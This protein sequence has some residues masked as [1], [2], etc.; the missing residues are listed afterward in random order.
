MN[1]AFC[2]WRE[3][4]ALALLAVIKTLSMWKSCNRI[5]PTMI[6]GFHTPDAVSAAP[7]DAPVI[8]CVTRS[9]AVVDE[10]ECLWINSSLMGEN[11]STLAAQHDRDGKD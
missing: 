9:I 1:N 8:V 4:Y 10:T 6:D 2:E 11:S 3:T 5:C 7:K